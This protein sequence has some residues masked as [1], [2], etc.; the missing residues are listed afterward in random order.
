LIVWI[1]AQLSPYLA[2]WLSSEFD[3]DAKPIRE[4]GLRD[5]GDQEIFM[6]AREAGAVVLTKDSDFVLLLEQL[7][8][9][10]QILWLTI[11]NTS[12]AR[13]REVLSKNFPTV[14]SL[15]LRGEPL[16]EISE[17]SSTAS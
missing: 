14:Q 17:A 10:P 13:L 4:L 2:P 12:N 11:G 5:A 8:P 16:V 1:D 9:P 3:I 6:A 15:L 7:G